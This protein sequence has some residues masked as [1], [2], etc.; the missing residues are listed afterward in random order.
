MGLARTLA[1]PASRGG[2]FSRAPSQMPIGIAKITFDSLGLVANLVLRWVCTQEAFAAGERPGAADVWF[3]KSSANS[4][5]RLDGSG[6]TLDL[7]HFRQ[8]NSA[9]S[10][11]R[12]YWLTRQ[13]QHEM[14]ERNL[15]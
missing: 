13:S 2:G 14:R 1:L 12:P 6:T 11:E 15:L 5:G 3:T 10:K 7:S 9:T 4:G 8:G